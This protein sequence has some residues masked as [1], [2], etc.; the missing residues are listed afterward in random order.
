MS[1]DDIDAAQVV[2]E[3]GFRMGDHLDFLAGE[4]EV[5]GLDGPQAVEM[6]RMQAQACR[7]LSDDAMKGLLS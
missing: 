2:A 4:I 1:T 7:E 6:L 5:A 3:F